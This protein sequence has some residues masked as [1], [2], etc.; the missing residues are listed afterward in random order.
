MMNSL[1][2][3][4]VVLALILVWIIWVDFKSFIIPDIANASLLIIGIIQSVML[5]Q[6]GVLEVVAASALGGGVVFLLRQLY[7]RFR[8]IEGLGLGDVKFMIAAGTWISLVDVP[9]MMLLGCI[10]ALG[11]VLVTRAIKSSWQRSDRVAFGPHLA[12]G[13]ATVWGI[14]QYWS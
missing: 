14:E 2:F 9:M 10:S 7:F 8:G 11:T 13:L 1:H 5:Q 6:R 12:L 4:A 3:F